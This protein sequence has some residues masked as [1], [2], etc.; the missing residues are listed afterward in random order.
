[1]DYWEQAFL[2][3]FTYIGKHEGIRRL[4]PVFCQGILLSENG[5]VLYLAILGWFTGLGYIWVK[6][7]AFAESTL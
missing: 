7:K 6:R 3:N 4:I 5:W 2:Y 1:M